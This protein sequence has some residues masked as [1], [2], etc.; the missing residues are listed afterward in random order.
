[1][2]K[3]DRIKRIYELC[4]VMFIKVMETKEML[5]LLKGDFSAEVYKEKLSSLIKITARLDRMLEKLILKA[6][7]E[8]KL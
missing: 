3:I 7:K 1:M 6:Q 4:D 5:Y 8:I 2:K